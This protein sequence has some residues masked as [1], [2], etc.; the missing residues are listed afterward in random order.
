LRDD[1]TDASAI[2]ELIRDHMY[3]VHVTD[4]GAVVY[5]SQ[6]PEARSASEGEGAISPR[7][8]GHRDSPAPW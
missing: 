2:I 5:R 1:W 4:G 3:P 6:P 8:T 7:G